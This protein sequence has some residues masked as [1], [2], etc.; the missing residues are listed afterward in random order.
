MSQRLT[1]GL[2]ELDNSLNTNLL[3]KKVR[4]AALHYLQPIPALTIS[5]KCYLI[6]NLNSQWVLIKKYSEGAI[7]NHR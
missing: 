1:F 6:I 2:S 3:G 5:E 7:Q 4:T